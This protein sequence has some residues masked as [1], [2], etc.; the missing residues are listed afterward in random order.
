MNAVTFDHQIDR[1]VAV[2]S[3]RRPRVLVVEDDI[4]VLSFLKDSFMDDGYEVVDAC[5]LEEAL[6]SLD[7][8]IFDFI[9]TDWNLKNNH[10]GEGRRVVERA[11]Q[12][13]PNAVVAILTGTPFQIDVKVDFP[14]LSESQRQTLQV[15][16]K[17][18]NQ[19]HEIE[20]FFSQGVA[21]PD[22]RITVA[23]SSNISPAKGPP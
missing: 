16:A 15:F 18:I 6:A 9:S 14:D 3:F 11:F 10:D 22:P 13:N 12:Q 5:N 1:P 7:E 20:R 2:D 8:N 21:R 17:P 23:A 19:T 4:F